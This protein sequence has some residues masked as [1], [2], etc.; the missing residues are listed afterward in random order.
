MRRNKCI[1]KTDKSLLKKPGIDVIYLA[2][3][4]FWGME[5]LMRSITG[6]VAVTSGYANGTREV[7]TYQAV[8]TGLTGH[9][10]TVRVEYAPEKVS[11]DSLLFAYFSVIDPTRKNAQG[12]D[13]GT[14]YQAGIY[15]SDEHSKQTVERIA[16]IE[17]ERYRDFAVEIGPLQCFFD[18][19]EYHQHYLDKNPS[20]YCHIPSEEIRDISGMIIDP[21]DYQ[22]P[23]KEILKDKLTPYSI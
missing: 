7:P 1:L 18:A 2:G 4:C 11:L 23:A 6:V 20:G 15:Y 17:K 12:N 10:E 19:E 22:R 3:G 9:R 5:K 8:C 16:G 13:I 21:S 14:Q